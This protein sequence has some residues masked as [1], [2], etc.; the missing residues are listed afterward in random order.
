[1]LFHLLNRN[2]L[3]QHGIANVDHSREEDEHRVNLSLIQ[4]LLD[5]V[6]TFIVAMAAAWWWYGV[7]GLMGVYVRFIFIFNCSTR[8]IVYSGMFSFFSNACV[9]P[10]VLY[11]WP[12]MTILE[13]KKKNGTEFLMI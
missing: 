2:W 7:W 9:C 6:W 8:I 11:S 1:M 3:A 10:F 13:V 5:V 4:S 12:L